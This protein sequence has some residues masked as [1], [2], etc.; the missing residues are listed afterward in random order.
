M[1]RYW[2]E[3]NDKIERPSLSFDVNDFVLNITVDKIKL[4]DPQ[5]VCCSRVF[6]KNWPVTHS[7]LSS[8]P[9]V[10]LESTE[11]IDI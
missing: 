2:K 4:P 5:N 10:I 11:K 8:V 9:F 3:K 1:D 7:G 6:Y